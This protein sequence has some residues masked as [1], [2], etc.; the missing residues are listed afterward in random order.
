[1]HLE[2]LVKNGLYGE[3]GAIFSECKKYRY[4]LWRKWGKS[5]HS[6]YVMFVGLNPSTADESI[7]DPTIRRC[8][9]FA[10]DWGYD[11]LFMANL[12][13]YRATYPVDMF[14]FAEPIRS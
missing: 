6:K 1:M 9:C 13:A 5:P 3:S 12:F 8:I 7:D 11:G 2:S 4:L 10:K 14:K